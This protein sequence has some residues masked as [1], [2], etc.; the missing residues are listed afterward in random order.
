MQER[1]LNASIYNKELTIFRD[2]F[3]ALSFALKDNFS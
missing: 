3:Q 1:K 2:Q